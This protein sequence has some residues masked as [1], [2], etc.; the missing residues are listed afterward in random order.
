[1]SL[2]C[3]DSILIKIYH[4]LNFWTF[5][6]CQIY[7]RAQCPWIITLSI[8]INH[9]LSLHVL[10]MYDAVRFNVCMIWFVKRTYRY[11]IKQT[12]FVDKQESWL[13]TYILDKHLH[14]HIYK[15]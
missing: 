4:L 2:S 8:E 14:V 10:P 13:F 6:S 15:A 9:P 3:K 5:L 1:M 12:I 11:I 7:T